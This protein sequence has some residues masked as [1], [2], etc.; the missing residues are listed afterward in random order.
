MGEAAQI[1]VKVPGIDN[2]LPA[3]L[4]A[5]V[6]Q[7]DL[8]WA[9]VS[10][11]D[12]IVVFLEEDVPVP[13]VVGLVPSRDQPKDVPKA[14]PPKSTHPWIEADVDGR[15]IRI[16]AKDEIVFECGK[17]S[18]TLRR[19]GKVIVRGTD[20]ETNALGANRIR[21]GQVKIN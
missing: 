3:T 11:H 5:N 18:I 4:S 20:V 10:H 15:Q 21:G 7:G 12:A 13:V 9:M 2:P 1:F 19:N 14:A 8:R 16:V 17:A 6:S